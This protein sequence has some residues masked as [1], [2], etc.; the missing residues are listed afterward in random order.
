MDRL[1]LLL[2]LGVAPLPVGTTAKQ[3]A[4]PHRVYVGL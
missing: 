2:M 4:G 3:L 1:A